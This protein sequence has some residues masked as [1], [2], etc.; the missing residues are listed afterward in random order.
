MEMTD[1]WKLPASWEGVD[2]TLAG[3]EIGA[4]THENPDDFMEDMACSQ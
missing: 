1:E 4:G 3:W 2:P